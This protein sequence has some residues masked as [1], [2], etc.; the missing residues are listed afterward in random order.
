MPNTLTWVPGTGD[1]IRVINPPSQA[2]DGLSITGPNMLIIGSVGSIIDITHNAFAE[3]VACVKLDS[4]PASYFYLFELELETA[5]SQ[6]ANQDLNREAA[7]EG[8]EATSS[9]VVDGVDI[10]MDQLY[11]WERI[12][13][14]VRPPIKEYFNQTFD[15]EQEVRDWIRRNKP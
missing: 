4:R 6:R 3:E 2:Y 15:T 11:D 1:R 8:P 12:P 7:L 5:R 9:V 13:G 14:L 10:V